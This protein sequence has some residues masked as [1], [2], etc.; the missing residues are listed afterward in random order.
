MILAGRI[1]YCRLSVGS[2]LALSG[3]EWYDG[4]TSIALGQNKKF[5]TVFCLRRLFWS[6]I[7]G[8]F[9]MKVPYPFC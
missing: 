8:I 7:S 2:L 3:R 9:Q 4:L 5:T 6:G 1:G